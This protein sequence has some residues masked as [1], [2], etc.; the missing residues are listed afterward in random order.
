MWRRQVWRAVGVPRLPGTAKTLRMSPFQIEAQHLPPP[1]TENNRA[2]VVKRSVSCREGLWN[3]WNLLLHAAFP[4]KA[5][6]NVQPPVVYRSYLFD[7]HSSWGQCHYYCVS[8]AV[9]EVRLRSLNQ[10]CAGSPAVIQSATRFSNASWVS[11][12]IGNR[13][14]LILFQPYRSSRL[15]KCPHRKSPALLQP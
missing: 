7:P 8:S 15:P 14:L 5:P 9:S 1:P 6:Y 10:G 13:S 4:T 12:F 3:L 11:L 2:V